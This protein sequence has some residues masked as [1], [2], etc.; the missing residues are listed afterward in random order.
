MR[1]GQST[2]VLSLIGAGLGTLLGACSGGGGDGGGG[3][4]FKITAINLQAGTVWRI[5]RPIKI[6]FS[7]AVDI[8]SVNLNTIN[9]RRVGGGPASGEFYLEDGDRTVVFQPLCPTKSDLSDSGLLAGTDPNNNDSA[10]SYEL[11]IIGVDKSSQLPVRSVGGDALAASQTRLFT[12]P[13][14]LNPLNLYLDTKV[15]PPVPRVIGDQA[16]TDT[17]NGTY[18]E[19]GGESGTKH[20]FERQGGNLVINPPIDLPLNK[21][22][23]TGSQVA[24]I[25]GFDQAVDPS[26]NNIS[27][28]RVRWEFQDAAGAWV[29]LATSVTLE[30][31]CTRTGSRVRVTPEGLM[32]PTATVRA[33][34]TPEFVDIV[35]ESNIVAQNNFAIVSTEAFPTNPPQLID[36]YL[37]D[38]DT[39]TNDDAAASFAEPHADWGNGSLAAK[40]SF[41]GTGGPT[42]DFDWYIGPGEIV[43]FNTANSAI[44]GFNITY[45]TGTLV[46]QTTTPIGQQ[47]VVGGVVDVRDFYIEAGGTV[48]VEGPNPFVVMAS[49]NVVIRGKLDVNGTSSNGVNTLDTTNLPEP[50]S[51]GQAGGGKGGTGSPLTTASS[52]KGGNGSGAWNATDLGGQGGETG[53]SNLQALALRRGAGGGGG[54]L[55]PAQLSGTQ[56]GACSPN[57]A[58][59][60]RIGFDAEPGFN[61][62]AGDNGA[63]TGAPGPFGGSAG[64]SPFADPNPGNNFYGT[65]FNRLTNAITVG[66]LTRPWAG[67]G[68]GAG[69]DASYISSGAFPGPWNPTGDEK[70]SGGA[71]GGGSVHI[72]ALGPIV[73]GQSGL[74]Q[75]R[76]GVGGGGENT[77]FLNRVGGGSGGGSGGHVVMQS[78]DRID[79]SAK[80]GVNFLNLLDNAWAIDC[81]GGQGGAGDTDAGG[82]TQSPQGQKETNPASDACPAGYQTTGPLKCAGQV[83][84]AGGDGGPGIIQLHTSSG[85]IGT[86]GGA[87]IIVPN[88]VTID[89]LCAPKPLCWDNT[90]NPGT[91]QMVPTFG[92][93]SRAR[94]QWIAL[95]EGGFDANSTTYKDVEFAFDGINTT[96]GFVQTDGQGR[97]LGL[98]P[99][100]GPTAIDVLGVTPPYVVTPG[101]FQIVMDAS[102]LIGTVNE[103]LL[104]NTDLLQHYLVELDDGATFQRFDIVVASYSSANQ[105]LTL[106][107]DGDGPSMLD[108]NLTPSTTA[109]LQPAFFRV[110]SSGVDDFLPSSATVKIQLEATSADPLTGLPDTGV[111]AVVGPT[112][113]VSVL[114][115]TPNG[116]LRFVRFTVLFDINAQGGAI[117]ASNPIPRIEFFRLPFSYQ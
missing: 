8:A 26:A 67:A 108:F 88:G 5:N 91:C 54:T 106:T 61:N 29:P 1:S 36:H 13:V 53:W 79:F 38:F 92:R 86:S 55:G 87:D 4:A 37:E 43:I 16:D 52:P 113:D 10:Y 51:P 73:F 21:L 95:G 2:L 44:N 62:N 42:G 27:P 116:D 17:S 60:Q 98:T 117:S 77:I 100:L 102:S 112:S 20:Y 107:I 70:G 32:P 89:R 15:G 48:K 72:M 41:T 83:N 45:A 6:T 66:E 115:A 75:A 71:G 7:E 69:G 109:E 76:G 80:L 103:E 11:N 82:G 68:G 110:R 114:N 18:I 33:V 19:V 46:A 23:D 65:Q 50:G 47:T 14:S 93:T 49:G 40:F 25:V 104:N 34:V 74:L 39:A 90:S 96:T 64:P 28:T 57:C 35:G 9:V 30:N 63:L 94:S 85:L 58:E 97:V 78:A 24:L 59:Q 84:G 81:R 105:R 12:T 3:G 31:N 22:S 111:G 56:T 99:V 101:G